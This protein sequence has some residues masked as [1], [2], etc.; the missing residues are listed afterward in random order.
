MATVLNQFIS[1]SANRCKPFFSLINKWKGFEWTEE[2]ALAFQKLKD[3][4][5]RPP[6]MSSPESDEILFAY[7]AVAPYAISLKAIL[8]VVLGTQKLPHYFQAYTVVVLT[9]LSLKI[10]LR[11]ADYTGRIAKWG[12]ILG[13]FDIKYMPRTSV[14]GQVLADLV[15]EFTEP[16]VE[17]L[18]PAQNMDEKSIGMISQ[19]GS[20]FW[21]VYM[22]GAVNQKG[23]GVGLVLISPEMIII[24]K[25]LRLSFTAINN[26]AEYETLLMGMAMVQ[27]M[28]RRN[29]NAHADSLATL[30]T[31]SVQD[32]PRVILV[33]DLHKPTEVRGEVVRI[34]QIR[35]ELSW[36]DPIIKFLKEDILPEE[37]SEANKVQRNATRFWLSENQKLYKRSYSG[38]YLLCMH[39][40]VAESLLEELHE[41]I[42]G[43]HTGGRSL[44][45][46]ALTQ[47]YWWPNMQREAHE[48]VKKCDQCQRFAPNIHQPSGILNP[49]S[50]PWPFAQW[51]LD[52]VG[53]FPKVIGNKKY[54][55]FGI[56]HTL[57]SDNGL[58]FDSKTF[59]NYCGELGIM[60]R[61]STPAYP[62]GNETTPRRSTR[63]TPFSMTYGTEAVIPLEIGF[64]MLR[65][66]SFSPSS[67][68]KLLERSLD[69][70]EKRRENA[71]VQLAHYQQKLRQG[72]NANVKLKP[73][74]SGDLVLSKVVGI[75]KNPAWGK[76][77]PNWEM[78]YYITSGAGIGA[79]FL[80]DLDGHGQEGS[81]RLWAA[82]RLLGVIWREKSQS[83]G[84]CEFQGRSRYFQAASSQTLEGPQQ[85]QGLYPK[86]CHNSL[87]RLRRT[88]Q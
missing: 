37:R 4:L 17:E 75:T 40:K 83:L 68:N 10:V 19:Q 88:P 20:L 15:A 32:L 24:E 6:I 28:G 16:S 55:L 60:N 85:Y 57:I 29:G 33:E 18:E 26:E 76:L 67:N 12:T 63:E 84:V 14:K 71:M 51:G 27:R 22:D 25:L 42:Y 49:L 61:Y 82:P 11:S 38:P 23:S 43:S 73:L 35:A 44:A 87:C 9:Q 64:P 58:Q 59:R 41:G 7:I 53:P 46:R 21:E 54:L 72:Y 13:A 3:Y 80:E 45:H 31:S 47:G 39:P 5:A 66:S 70:I 36:M 62:Q 34:H 8:A 81:D 69:L 1:Q 48:Y 56:P 30:A 78:P 65:T 86:L 79:Y 74:T 2:C 77:G 50:S 52:I